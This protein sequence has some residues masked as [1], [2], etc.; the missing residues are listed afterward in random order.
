M[1]RSMLAFLLALGLTV[2]VTPVRA[3]TPDGQTPAQE[4]ICSPLSGAAFGVC[5][6]Y[7][8]A[9]DCDVHNRLSCRA[10]RRGF[11][12]LTGSPVFPC[13]MLPCGFVDAPECAGACPNGG[14]CVYLGDTHGESPECGCQD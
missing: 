14:E 8:E 1:H 11:Q 9:Q 12:K 3:G 7:C 13:D 2:T 5:N 4:S 10:L 6:A